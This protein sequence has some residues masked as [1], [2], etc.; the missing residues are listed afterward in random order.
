M[1]QALPDIDTVTSAEGM[2]QMFAD[3][4]SSFWNLARVKLI[5]QSLKK[6][7]LLGNEKIFCEH[8]CGTG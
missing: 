3:E 2:Q 8:G 5:T 4:E 7:K 6:Y 1:S